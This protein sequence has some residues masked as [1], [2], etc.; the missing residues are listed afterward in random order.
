MPSTGRHDVH[1]CYARR[2]PLS[3]LPLAGA[4]EPKIPL[5]ARHRPLLALRRARCGKL[6]L[7]RPLRL[8]PLLCPPREPSRD[9]RRISSSRYRN[10]WPASGSVGPR[11]G[12]RRRD[13]ERG[14][15][16]SPM[17]SRRPRSSIRRTSPT[18]MPP[19]LGLLA[20]RARRAD[21]RATAGR[22]RSRGCSCAARRRRSRSC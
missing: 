12:A 2:S 10:R 14:P 1:P 18:H 15:H 4:A 21:H 16:P 22:A 17:R 11:A 6:H 8:L 9:V 19:M 13:R 3:P 20:A 7:L 5:A